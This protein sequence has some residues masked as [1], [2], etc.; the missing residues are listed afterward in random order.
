VLADEPPVGLAHPLV[1]YAATH[2]NL[3]LT[4]HIGGYTVE[5][6]AKTELH[7]TERLLRLLDERGAAAPASASSAPPRPQP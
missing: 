3:M 4:P 1:R 2:A 7:L 5:S 6:L